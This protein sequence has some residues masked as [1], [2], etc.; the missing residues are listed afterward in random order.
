MDGK[1]FTFV[2]FC[3]III[4][5]EILKSMSV[6]AFTLIAWKLAFMTNNL[7]IIHLIV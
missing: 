6:P 3:R 2:R 1:K 4:K 7:V 5:K